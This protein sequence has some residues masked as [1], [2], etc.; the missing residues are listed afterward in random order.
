MSLIFIVIIS[1]ILFAG[2]IMIL[3]LLI[4]FVE[5]KVVKTGDRQI[6]INDETVP[7]LVE[8][9]RTLLNTLRTK[10][11]Y[12]PSACGGK[13]TCGECKCQVVD[14]GGQVL[15]TEIGLLTRAQ[16]K[17][18]YRLG[19]QLKVREDVKLRLPV[20]IFSIQQFHCRV[21]SNR[22]I[23][24][25]IK[26]LV[27]DLPRGEG[28]DFKPGQYVQIEVPMY[29]LNYRDFH[30]DEKFRSDWDKYQLWDLFSE[31]EEDVS[32]AYSMANYPQEKGQLKLNVRIATPPPKN[33]S[34]PT[35]I[36]SSYIYGLKPGD[37]VVLSGPY[38]E[39]F[40][41]ETKQEMIYIGGGAGM[42][43][44]R[45]HLF[46]LLKT[47]KTTD[48][49][50][51]FWYGARSQKE[52]FYADEFR[53]LEKEFS[54]FSFCIALSAPLPEDNWKGPQGFIH[55]VVFDQ[56]LKAHADPED[57]E[58]YLCGPPL[59]LAAVRNMLDNLGVPEEMI[60]FDSFG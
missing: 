43:P 37:D 16:Q 27:V 17:N 36:A 25:F 15:P 56:Y 38:G 46:Y 35:G 3:S 1:S 5:K 23:A 54:N 55:Q 20:E 10:E 7:L 44:L 2:I 30:V 57:I 52:I 47:L 9:G 14:G 41:K 32:R 24:T 19:C 21:H 50:I 18:G 51:S 31:N 6:F 22:S 45:S 39:F 13:G 4:L 26:E 53:R 60:A 48:R 42:A 8:G 12:L 59:M 34:L 29:I 40:I 58:Y 33:I 11:I 49:K 28:F